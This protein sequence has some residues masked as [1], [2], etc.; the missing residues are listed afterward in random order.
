M[1]GSVKRRPDGKWRARYRDATG[2]E[3]AR[4][5]DRKADAERWVAASTTAVA[6]G[7]WI[8]PAKSR[9]TVKEWSTVWL[10][11]KSHLRPRTRELYET[12]LRV[13][14]L[15]R[16][17][18]VP[19]AAITHTDVVTWMSDL[20]EERSPAVTRHALLVL[21]Q[22]LSLAVRDGRLARNVADGVARP[23]MARPVQRFLT[24][25]EIARLALE[26]PEPYDLLVTLLAFTG[27]RF[28]EVAEL[29]W[30]DLDLERLTVVSVDGSLLQPMF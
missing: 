19:L 5:F 4:H 14:V 21:T 24:H 26:L 17:E 30:R 7:D 29:R 1:A 18:R 9:I 16:W 3:H 13:W 25:D 23:R 2:K 27:L 15:P 28:G 10:A 22:M 11:T 8:D 6:R 12:A 20:A